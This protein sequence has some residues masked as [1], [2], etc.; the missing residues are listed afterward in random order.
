MATTTNYGWT[1]PNDTDLVKNGA[2]AM[3]TLGTAVDNTLFTAL[4]GNYPGLRLIKKQTIGTAVSSVTV[5]NAF[6]STYDNY[7]IVVNGGTN[8]AGG[9]N[10]GFRLGSDTLLYSQG[11]V[12]YVWASGVLDK[13]GANSSTSW[14]YVGYADT[15]SIRVGLNVYYPN[16]AKYTFFDGVYASAANSGTCNGVHQ[17]SISYTDFTL[18]SG[19]GTL[20]GG[21]I[22]VY[23]YGT[24]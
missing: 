19:T 7:R 5:T 23:G 9:S 11:L 22:Y 24:N 20:T 10:I 6:S 4:G 12:Y 2:S 3:R 13:T 14:P 8:S 17:R 15:D 21:T 16:A 18:I 1:T